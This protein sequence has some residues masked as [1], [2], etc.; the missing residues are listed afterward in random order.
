MR[1]PFY[2]E[3]STSVLA[4]VS[5]GA[6]AVVVA[7]SP[8]VVVAAASVV[9]V[10][11]AAVVGAAVELDELLSLPHAAATSESEMMPAIASRRLTVFTS[12]VSLVFVARLRMNN[13]GH[14]R[15]RS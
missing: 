10:A 3:K 1:L 11:A 7:A 13:G 9:G 12:C 14:R 5:V 8:A 2:A 15:S 6:A 4:A